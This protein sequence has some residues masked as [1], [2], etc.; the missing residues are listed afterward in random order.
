MT[1]IFTDGTDRPIGTAPTYITFDVIAGETT[2]SFPVKVTP[3][4]D[5]TFRSSSHALIKLKARE[6]GSGDPYA[7][8]ATGIDLSGYPAG[9]PV[10]FDLICE[11]SALLTGLVRAI[12][13]LVVSST[14]AANWDL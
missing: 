9:T 3:D 6:T 8:L 13:A 4:A 14:S 7:D 1:A 2:T 5:R 12:F 10:S 11:C